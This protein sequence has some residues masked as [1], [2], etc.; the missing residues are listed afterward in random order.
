[1]LVFIF[2]TYSFFTISHMSYHAVSSVEYLLTRCTL[3][4][5]NISMNSL[6]VTLQI[7]LFLEL[8]ITL[9]T[10]EELILVCF[11]CMLIE[12]LPGIESFVTF[13]THWMTISFMNCYIFLPFEFF[14]AFL[15][16]ARMYG[17]N[18]RASTHII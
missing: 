13:L 4:V 1:M 15:T 18:W 8:L 2:Q 10:T 5:I 12:T 17:M 14:T 6:F 16:L 7:T 3:Q 9:L 11:P